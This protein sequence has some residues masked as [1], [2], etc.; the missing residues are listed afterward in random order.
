MSW[1]WLDSKLNQQWQSLL[2]GAPPVS[3]VSCLCRIL[4]TWKEGIFILKCAQVVPCAHWVAIITTPMHADMAGSNGL[5]YLVVKSGASVIR[6][7]LSWCTYLHFLWKIVCFCLEKDYSA[8]WSIMYHGDKVLQELSQS[9][10]VSMAQTVQD[11]SIFY[12]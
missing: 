1:Y 2:I 5:P 8:N 4:S 9:V 10:H 3:Q 12:C 6:F 11:S 7:L